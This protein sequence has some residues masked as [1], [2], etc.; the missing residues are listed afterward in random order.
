MTSIASWAP[1]GAKWTHP[2]GS[3]TIEAQRW[4][5]DLWLR[6][7]GANAPSNTD[8]AATEYADAGIEE[9]RA[10]MFRS[11]DSLAQSIS[12]RVGAIESERV[13]LS[14]LSDLAA[15]VEE[16]ERELN[17]LKQGLQA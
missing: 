12:E 10:G 15:R 11:T 4:L 3:L 8:L 5:R 14:N 17:A 7:G 6:I 2:D 9:I 16:L 1:P 13:E